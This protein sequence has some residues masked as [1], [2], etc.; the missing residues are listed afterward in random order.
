M[1][2]VYEFTAAYGVTKHKK[3]L[4]SFNTECASAT[5]SQAIPEA[6]GLNRDAAA[7]LRKFAW[8]A[9]KVL[10]AIEY[11]PDKARS[12]AHFGNA[13][14]PESGPWFSHDGEG[15]ALTMMIN[16]RGKLVQALSTDPNILVAGAIDGTDP[17]NP[18]PA[19]MGDRKELV[20]AVMNTGCGARDVEL[21][22]A[23]PTGTTFGE[24]TIRKNTY[25]KDAV[26]VSESKAA[27]SGT[28]FAFRQN[29]GVRELAVLTLPLTGKPADKA[30]VTQRQFFSKDLLAD[31]SVEKPLRT[32]I[33]VDEAALKGAKRAMLSLVVERLAQGEGTVVINGKGYALPAGHSAEN[34]PVLRRMEIDAA[35]LRPANELEFKVSPGQAGFFVAAASV[36]VVS[37]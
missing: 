37:E 11:A 30:Q 18:R 6:A 4:Y 2:G 13:N 21:R 24:G 3:W 19:E 23:A 9:A 12:M 34:T 17:L 28:A 1:S 32:A 15:K 5:D 16:L 33:A 22:I 10:H 31:V 29:L 35:G 25:G 7:N 20:V 14:R 8:T 26:E 36:I 27:A